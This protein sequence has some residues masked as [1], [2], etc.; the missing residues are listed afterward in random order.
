MI[1]EIRDAVRRRGFSSANLV[2]FLMRGALQKSYNDAA[3]DFDFK[4]T[5]KSVSHDFLFKK[6]RLIHPLTSALVQCETQV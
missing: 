2:I 1:R 3:Q 5:L 4:L 6:L